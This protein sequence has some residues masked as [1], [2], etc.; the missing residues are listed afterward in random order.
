[1]KADQIEKMCYNEVLKTIIKSWVPN[2]TSFFCSSNENK[3]TL[4][5]LVYLAS[6]CFSYYKIHYL[7]YI[8]VV[9]NTINKAI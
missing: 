6:N 4:W 2:I 1:M 3:K 9:K 7:I 8:Y 5:Q